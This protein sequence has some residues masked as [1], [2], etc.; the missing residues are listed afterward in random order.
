MNPKRII[1]IQNVVL[2][3][4][5]LAIIIPSSG[6]ILKMLLGSR[7][8]IFL[9]VVVPKSRQPEQACIM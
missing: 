5:Y 1:A 9:T 4:N 8:S 2:S 7:Y 3:I 6:V